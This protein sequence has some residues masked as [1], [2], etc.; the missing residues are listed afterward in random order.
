MTFVRILFLALFFQTPL[1]TSPQNLPVF[2]NIKFG[3]TINTVY[4]SLI[5]ISDSLKV[6][7]NDNPIFPLSRNKEAHL[8]TYKIRLKNGTLD[9]AVFTF[10]DSGLSY[11]E[12]QGNVLNVFTTNRVGKSQKFLDFDV[13]INDL[14]FVNPT[15]DAAWILTK[16]SV[17]PNLFTWNNPLLGD[18]ESKI[19]YNSSAKLPDFIA[20]GHSFQDLLPGF[21]RES[22]IIKVDTLDGSDP[23]AQIQINCYGIEYA[24]FP[25]KFEARFG[26]NKLNMIWILTGKEEEARIRKKLIEAY[27]EAI[28]INDKWEFYKDWTVALRKDKPEILFVSKQLGLEYKKQLID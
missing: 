15:K 3:D 19:A 27:G 1:V 4:Q 22:Q 16:E 9:K 8:L 12:C 28:F 2:N 18:P 20:T 24:G 21:K 11:V 23:N 14:L 5:G 13:Y 10:T 17:H 26:N 25:R 7:K 6:I